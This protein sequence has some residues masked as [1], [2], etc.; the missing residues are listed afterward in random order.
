[1]KSSNE[2]HFRLLNSSGTSGQR[3]SKIYLDKE[4]VNNQIKVLSK[5][6]TT[7]FGNEDFNV[8]HWE[9]N[10]NKNEKLNAKNAAIRGFSIFAKKQ[11][12]Q[13][14]IMVK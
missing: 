4:N 8:N 12:L 6:F 9:S 11:V 10:D 7:T 13:N 5:L 14:T 2:P 1:M 3:L